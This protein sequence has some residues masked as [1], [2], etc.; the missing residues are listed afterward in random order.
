MADDF[1]LPDEIRRAAALYVKRGDSIGGP[2]ARG[3][4][5]RHLELGRLAATY[6]LGVDR[7]HWWPA[8]SILALEDS[9]P[10]EAAVS[11]G[12]ETD[13]DWTE[14]RRR[15]RRRWIDERSGT[16]RR[17]LSEAAAPA[18]ARSGRDRRAPDSGPE[19][20]PQFGAPDDAGATGARRSLV[21]VTAV[22][23]VLVGIGLYAWFFGPR[24]APRIQLLP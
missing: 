23:V 14:E 5:E 21:I 10:V 22:I 15:A 8:E 2:F 17:A 12:A 11:P 24:L 20:P 1:D 3:L 9:L 19:L 16:D 13:L 7:T 6:L 18:E 4:L